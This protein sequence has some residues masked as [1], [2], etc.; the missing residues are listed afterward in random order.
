[1]QQLTA[2]RL[3]THMYDWSTNCWDLVRQIKRFMSSDDLQL[4]AEAAATLIGI[5]AK[6]RKAFDDFQASYLVFDATGQRLL[7]VGKHKQ[8]E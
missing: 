7:M 8:T 6:S 2:L 5:D 3:S 4:Q 1:M